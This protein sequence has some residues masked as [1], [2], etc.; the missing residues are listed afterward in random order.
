MGS[1]HNHCTTQNIVDTIETDKSKKDNQNATELQSIG[2]FGIMHL[3]LIGVGFT[4][5]NRQNG[6]IN[7]RNQVGMIQG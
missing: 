3:K 6:T 4:P 7:H 2:Q 5:Q 1:Q